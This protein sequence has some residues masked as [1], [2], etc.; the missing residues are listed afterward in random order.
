MFVTSSGISAMLGGLLS[1]LEY[2]F[3]ESVLFVFYNDRMTQGIFCAAM[4]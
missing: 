4:H 3:P 2:S 1:P